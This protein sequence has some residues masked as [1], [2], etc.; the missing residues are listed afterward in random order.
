M[1]HKDKA[2]IE[3]SPIMAY[4]R[5]RITSKG[6]AY[7]EESEEFGNDHYTYH[8]ERTKFQ[9]GEYDCSCIYG[10]TALRGQKAGCTYGWPTMIECMCQLNGDIEPEPKT[11]EEIVR[12]I[13]IEEA[14]AHGDIRIKDPRGKCRRIRSIPNYSGFGAEAYIRVGL[15]KRERQFAACRE[16]AVINL[17]NRLESGGWSLEGGE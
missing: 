11:V 4:L 12:F 10:H 2:D 1:E 6:I 3:I 13:D 9:I 7:R 14:I 5:S 17:I 15:F 16:G 8:M